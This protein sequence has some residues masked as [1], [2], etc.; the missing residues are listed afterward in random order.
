M[1]RVTRGQVLTGQHSLRRPLAAPAISR[2]SHALTSAITD[3]HQNSHSSRLATPSIAVRTLPSPKMVSS[4]RQTWQIREAARRNSA[5]ATARALSYGYSPKLAANGK[6]VA[7]IELM[8]VVGTIMVVSGGIFAVYKIADN[9]QRVSTEIKNAGEIVTKLNSIM[10]V[11]GTFVGLDQ[12]KAK[13]DK[14]FPERMIAGNQVNSVWGGVTLDAVSLSG[15]S[16]WGARLT[17]NNVPKDAC[18]NFVRSAASGFY[19][20]K[21]NGD[22][23]RSNYSNIQPTALINLCNKRDLGTVELIYAKNS[24]TGL[25]VGP[26]SPCV[27][28]PTE[29][30]VSACPPGQLGT[31]TRTRDFMCPSLYGAATA[32]PWSSPTVSCAPVCVLPNPVSDTDIETRPVS[33]SLACPAGQVTPAGDASFTQTRQETRSRSRT[34]FCPA[35]T[36]DY[37]WGAYGAFT[38]WLPSSGSA[39][40]WTP[41]ALTACAPKCVAPAPLVTSENNTASCPSGQSTAGGSPTFAQTRQ[42]TVTYS[43][44]SPTGA[45]T[46]NPA[47]YSPWTPAAPTV[48]AP[49]CVAPPPLTE[50]RA[51]PTDSQSQDFTQAGP[52]ATQSQ[53]FTQAGPVVSQSQVFTQA[54]PVATQSGSEAQYPHCAAGQYGQRHQARTVTQTSATTQSRTGTQTSPTTQSRTGTQTSPTTQVRTGTRTSA[55][56]QART[57][58]YTC[59]A[60]TGAYTSTTTPW[61]DT[62]TR[63]WSAYSYTPWVDNGV[64]NWS[65]YSYGAWADTGARNWSAFTYTPW[66]DTGARNWSAP[67]YG[68]WYDTY[69][70]CNACPGPSS[71]ANYQWV[72]VSGGACQNPYWWGQN[73]WNELQVQYRT[74]SYSCP[75]GTLNL[76]GPSYTGWGGWNWTGQRSGE[77]S[78]YLPD[79][80]G[81]LES[82]ARRYM[83]IY[84]DLYNAFNGNWAAA[85][86]HWDNAGYYEGRQSCWPAPPT[87]SPKQEI[88][89]Q[90]LGCPSG[91]RVVTPGRQQRT[92]YYTCP[93]PTITSYSPWVTI[94]FA[95][96]CPANRQCQIN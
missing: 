95:Q 55:T 70:T 88:Q 19:E 6:G 77:Q 58:T 61:A 92:A 15:I 13:A 69:N 60:P 51:G 75:A 87:C 66:A 26:L 53:V 7:L 17:Y 67:S 46:T 4:S 29:T 30:Q 36:G 71:E 27:A 49:T 14:L 38:P 81:T 3:A 82:Q 48:C 40:L 72:G 56:T 20:V 9:R 41:T 28:P 1:N 83:A 44:P 52:I 62:G 22:V 12:D 16:N 5:P 54:G 11:Q 57:T 74:V 73:Y 37:S 64:R 24:G 94:T 93:G 78:C 59:P 50:T 32:L 35:P 8:L 89:Y 96:C 84:Q 21:V 47:T 25:A 2:L 39:G 85:K 90:N 18:S 91:Q 86:S 65:A 42:K 76:P 34:A 79:C 68:N 80:G 31:V 45:Y 43:C 23:L 63:N 33:Q 10:A